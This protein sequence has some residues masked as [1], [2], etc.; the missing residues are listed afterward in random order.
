[1]RKLLAVLLLVG[2]LTACGTTAPVPTQ[3]E[4]EPEPPL[5]APTVTLT[6]DVYE[7][8][9]GTKVDV[10]GTST[11]AVSVQVIINGVVL[12]SLTPGEDGSWSTLWLAAHAGSYEVVAKAVNAEGEYT[13]SNIRTVTVV[14]VPTPTP[15][16]DPTPDPTPEVKISLDNYNS[17]IT[18]G[19]TIR[20][21]G[22][23]TGVGAVTLVE[24]VGSEFDPFDTITVETD[25]NGDWELAWTP[26]EIRPYDMWLKAHT[27][28]GSSF[29][30]A[31]FNV[32]V[33]GIDTGRWTV[34][35][36]ES[37]AEILL[38]DGTSLRMFP[39]GTVLFVPG[40]GGQQW[41]ADNHI[42][43][44]VSYVYRKST[45]PGL[46]FLGFAWINRDG[47][48]VYSLTLQPIVSRTDM[49]DLDYTQIYVNG[50]EAALEIINRTP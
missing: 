10:Y 13:V 33:V 36:D 43:Q 7:V 9:E 4:P 14:T 16:P 20:V 42:L 8:V 1:M 26:R 17:V 40:T 23:S 32:N 41:L 11:G 34:S 44:Q 49:L 48:G 2:A 5:P 47:R 29:T 22:T 31:A 38:E 3:P 28:D 35:E 45:S 27:G 19:E 25:L 46:L 24:R 18:I 15:D 37:E 6:I 39:D 21:Y 30:Q 50:W 12:G